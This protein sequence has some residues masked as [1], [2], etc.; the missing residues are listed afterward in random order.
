MMF[1]KGSGSGVKGF[2]HYDIYFLKGSILALRWCWFFPWEFSLIFL[3]DAT[4]AD[5]DTVNE[6]LKH[7]RLMAAYWYIISRANGCIG[8]E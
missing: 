5:E 1:R 7:G 4:Q 6:L 2:F 3:E 8:I